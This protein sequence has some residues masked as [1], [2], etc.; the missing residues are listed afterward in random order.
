MTWVISQNRHATN[1]HESYNNSYRGY[2]Y[3][4]KSTYNIVT[5]H[6]GP[7]PAVITL[8]QTAVTVVSHTP[9]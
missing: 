9:P 1:Q 7:L 6:K 8:W 4:L 2:D 5:P 3:F